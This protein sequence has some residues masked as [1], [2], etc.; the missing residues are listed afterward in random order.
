MLLKKEVSTLFVAI[1]HTRIGSVHTAASRP[2]TVPRLAK[3]AE[4]ETGNHAG[5]VSM[6]GD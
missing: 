4:E 2:A 3:S 1:L 5:N 6:N